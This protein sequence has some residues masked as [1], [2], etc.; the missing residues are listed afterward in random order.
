MG[1]V[2]SK[3]AELLGLYADL[4]ATNKRASEALQTERPGHVLADGATDRFLE[5]N[6]KASALILQI[7]A[8]QRA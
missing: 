8:M 3:A 7:K 4:R 5:E 2:V 1:I 6:K